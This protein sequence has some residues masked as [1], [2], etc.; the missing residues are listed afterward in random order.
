MKIFLPI[1][2]SL[3]L[4]ATTYQC[5]DSK[6]VVTPE[7]ITEITKHGELKYPM[8]KQ[9]WIG[10]CHDTKAPDG[11]ERYTCIEKDGNTF[12][13]VTSWGDKWEENC[14]AKESYKCATTGVYILGA[15][16]VDKAQIDLTAKDY[17]MK[18]LIDGDTIHINST[19]SYSAK[20]KKSEKRI[21]SSPMGQKLL[22][23]LDEARKGYFTYVPNNKYM[24]GITI[25]WN[26]KR[27]GLEIGYKSVTKSFFHCIP[28]KNK[29]D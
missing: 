16:T 18:M 11:R 7:S 29:R 28:N 13:F 12:K 21:S 20:L 8:R 19:D 15:W 27:E 24:E 14:S 26:P 2:L 10:Y 5:K 1:L 4:Q 17:D 3:S 22:D 9:K 23:A 6:L 25:T